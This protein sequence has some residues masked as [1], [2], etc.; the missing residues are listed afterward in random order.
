MV[1][2]HFKLLVNRVLP[3]ILSAWKKTEKALLFAPYQD[4]KYQQ[5]KLIKKFFFYCLETFFFI[6]YEEKKSQN[7]T[8]MQVI[9]LHS[10]YMCCFYAINVAEFVGNSFGLIFPC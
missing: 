10:V 7:N 8:M 3:D 5:K 2:C 1:A 6:K 9:D 4:C